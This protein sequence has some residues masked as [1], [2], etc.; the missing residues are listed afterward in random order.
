MLFETIRATARRPFS[1]LAVACLLALGIG[2]T[3]AVFS[4]VEALLLRPLPVHEPERLVRLVNVNSQLGPIS[5]FPRTVLQSIE[6]GSQSLAGLAGSFDRNIGLRAGETTERV[7][8]QFV[9]PGYLPRLGIEP[10]LGRHCTAGRSWRSATGVQLAT[11]SR[12][13]ASAYPFSGRYD[14]CTSIAF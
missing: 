9:T 5:E 6:E 12:A 4:G 11:G 8:L 1:S 14:S 13:I 7:R 10:T 3:T 2:V